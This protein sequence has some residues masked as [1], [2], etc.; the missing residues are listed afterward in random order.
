MA[1]MKVVNS[2]TIFVNKRSQFSIGSKT[3]VLE[4]LL[5]HLEQ[6]A[7]Q[8]TVALRFSIVKSSE[9]GLTVEST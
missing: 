4:Q 8:G 1:R 6:E 5:N 2:E 7:P 3:S 9:D